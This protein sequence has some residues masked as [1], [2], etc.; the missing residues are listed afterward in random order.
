MLSYLLFLVASFLFFEHYVMKVE[1]YFFHRMVKHRTL[2]REI[3]ASKFFLTCSMS[4]NNETL[5]GVV[6]LE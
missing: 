5:K 1:G 2:D 4:V 6:K 3:V